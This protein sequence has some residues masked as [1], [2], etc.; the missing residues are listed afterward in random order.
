MGSLLDIENQLEQTEN[1]LAS[2]KKKL[3][4]KMS[5][6]DALYMEA[7][8]KFTKEKET[9]IG[10]SG[11]LT[12]NTASEIE[13]QL[14]GILE[15]SKKSGSIKEIQL[16]VARLK[17]L[18]QS[19]QNVKKSINSKEYE[20]LE[21]QFDLI[22]GTIG[23][24]PRT[25]FGDRAKRGIAKTLPTLGGLALAL[26]GNHP[27]A[28]LAGA[29][30]GQGLE[31]RRSRK[32]SN[33]R[34]TLSASD[35][36]REK[37]EADRSALLQR[38][39]SELSSESAPDD[40]SYREPRSSRKSRQITEDE[41]EEITKGDLSE[42]V[43]YIKANS[44][45]LSE[46][47]KPLRETEFHTKNMEEILKE[48]EE[49]ARRSKFDLV[50]SETEASRQKSVQIPNSPT[51]QA[52]LEKGDS[53]GFLGTLLAI[54]GGKSLL[55]FGSVIKDLMF[56][57]GKIGP[58]ALAASG[59]MISLSTKL[60]P[61]LVAFGAGYSVLEGIKAAPE[62]SKKTGTSQT[63]ATIAGIISKPFENLLNLFGYQMDDKFKQEN[64]SRGLDTVGSGPMFSNTMKSGPGVMGSNLLMDIPG[65]LGKAYK[66]LRGRSNQDDVLELSSLQRQALEQGNKVTEAQQ[67][68]I[69]DLTEKV[70]KAQDNLLSGDS[71]TSTAEKLSMF[72]SGS[73]TAAQPT[74]SSKIPQKSKSGIVSGIASSALSAMKSVFSAT[75]AQASM[76]SSNGKSNLNYTSGGSAP[77]GA[78]KELIDKYAS[79]FGVD[80][81]LA[82]AL[83]MQ[84][85]G[86][87]ARAIG[88][89]GQAVGLFQLHPGAAADAGISP[90]DRKNPEKN[91]MAG[92]KYLS[93]KIQ[94]MGGDTYAGLAAYNEGAGKIKE[95]MTRKGARYAQDVTNRYSKLAEASKASPVE[96]TLQPKTIKLAELQKEN[97][98]LNSSGGNGQTVNNFSPVNQ[99][100]VSG[101]NS[102]SMGWAMSCRNPDNTLNRL[103]ETSH[104]FSHL[105][106]WG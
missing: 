31:N 4:A 96:P 44:E 95:G 35:S 22:S 1:D 55:K 74:T 51:T 69:L 12:S 102:S 88:D 90:E 75:P 40:D 84:E 3:A 11:D 71:N 16:E 105:T 49:R 19:F 59:A 5:R 17:N 100:N 28:I 54:V 8:D 64:V 91:I 47:Q 50:E 76:V 53:S 61:W 52:A 20:Y 27:L 66:G 23:S 32:E 80:P 93:M 104:V 46:F 79:Q 86:G 106:A 15:S 94:E 67:K 38:Y 82:Y 65:L 18:K 58:A 92:I 30:V 37:L 7:L 85:S 21:K 48:S 89:G 29:M 33:A 87:D 99:T 103:S 36:I 43:K 83:M 78:Y 10:L 42:I 62:V 101:G 45:L 13:K 98:N 41:S 25:K 9:V 24:D 56:S 81:K 73:T 57:L 14:Q 34:Y 39:Q 77:D 97:S 6:S 72:S 68:R 60:A 70:L 63:S 26:T 2:L